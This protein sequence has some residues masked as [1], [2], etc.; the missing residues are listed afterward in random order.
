M[1]SFDQPEND[2]LNEQPLDISKL[3]GAGSARF[4][5]PPPEQ[6]WESAAPK[7]PRVEWKSGAIDYLRLV[8]KYRV[9]VVCG[10]ITGLLVGHLIYQ[11]LADF[12]IAT[13]ADGTRLVAEDTFR[14]PNTFR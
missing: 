10:L 14:V 7:A 2:P 9:W 8:T 12:A 4:A 6:R 1:S 3:S 5:S 13:T 11:K